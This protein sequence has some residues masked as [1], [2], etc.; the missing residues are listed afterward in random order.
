MRG[1]VSHAGVC[2]ASGCT[3]ATPTK[4]LLCPKHFALVPKNLVQKMTDAARTFERSP[5]NDPNAC[6]AYDR[7]CKKV[8]ESVRRTVTPRVCVLDPDAAITEARRVAF[9]ALDAG[10]DLAVAVAFWGFY[11]TLQEHKVCFLQ[12]EELLRKWK[13]GHLRITSTLRAELLLFGV[14]GKGGAVT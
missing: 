9:A 10:G 14:V 2:A 4:K 5:A 1:A 8:L 6:E 11:G 7:A 12:T 3:T 13:A